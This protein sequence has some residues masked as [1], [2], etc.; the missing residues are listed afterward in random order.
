MDA[1]KIEELKGFVEHCKQNPSVLHTPSLAF[2]KNF[3]Q[4]LG[5]QIPPPSGKSVS[6]PFDFLYWLCWS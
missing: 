6:S 4:S 1:D 5:A 2:F 3:L